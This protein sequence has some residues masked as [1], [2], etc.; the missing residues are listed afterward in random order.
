MAT[1][2]NIVPTSREVESEDHSIS[3][4]DDSGL[5]NALQAWYVFVLHVASSIVFVACMLRWI[6]G[7]HFQTGSPSS[8]FQT[9]IPFYQ[10]QINGLV[11]LALVIIRLLASACTALLVWRMILVL[12]E[13]QGLT[14]AELTRMNNYRL[15]ILPRFDSILWSGWAILLAFFLWPPNFA[16][17]LANSSLAWTP[18]AK[19]FGSSTSI[20]MPTWH[21]ATDFGQV[22]YPEW[23]MRSLL[24]AAIMTGTDPGYAF[25]SPD[26]PLRRYFRPPV[27]MTDSSRISTTLPLAEFQIK[28]HDEG[29]DD[30][31][32]RLSNSTF[33]DFTAPF[34]GTYTASR[35]DG[36]VILVRDDPYDPDDEP[37][38]PQGAEVFTSARSVAVRVSHYENGTRLEDGSLA[39]ADTPCPNIS[40]WF[41]QLP[42]PAQAKVSFTLGGEGQFMG[43]DCYQIGT[44]TATAGIYAA[45]D[46]EILSAGSLAKSATC[47]LAQNASTIKEDWIAPVAFEMMSE[48]M[49]DTV[50]LNYTQ[51][52]MAEGL[53]A[54]TSGM[55]T[56]AYHA[57]W[58]SV[59][60]TLGA[61]N[62]TASIRVAEPMVQAGVSR[63]KLYVWLAMNLS[64]L[65]AAVL[66]YVALS[67]SSVKA[68]RDITLTPLMAD[69]SAITNCRRG[70]GL[71]DAATLS[72]KD[73]KLPRIKLT[74]DGTYNFVDEIGFQTRHE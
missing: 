6:D 53:D 63:G 25:N 37:N 1:K 66:M 11:S 42:G 14:L 7:H 4:P 13:K 3:R 43:A 51:Q 49:K 10:T 19:I 41:G 54:Y 20:T 70:I 40:P 5:W 72:R 24:N 71:R 34:P 12:L 68:I 16:A 30:L 50:M 47:F 18:A 28:W 55:V 60:D 38:T 46:C 17:P 59:M 29:E 22:N 9:D 69:F 45:T 21:N 8:I 33:T 62:E 73:R 65:V 39:N 52:Y 74:A 23:R 57:A 2:Y 44:V 56:L 48:I 15:P 36:S 35:R 31:S 67:F 32:D 26:L 61:D 27:N 58:S 64:L